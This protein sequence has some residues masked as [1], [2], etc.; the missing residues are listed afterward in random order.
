[1]SSGYKEELGMFGCGLKLSKVSSAAALA[2][3]LFISAFFLQDQIVA[4]LPAIKDLIQKEPAVCIATLAVVINIWTNIKTLKKSEQNTRYAV[5]AAYAQMFKQKIESCT[6]DFLTTLGTMVRKKL[7]NKEVAKETEAEAVEYAYHKLMEAQVALD[8]TN[9]LHS[10]LKDWMDKLFVTSLEKQPDN[11]KC[12]GEI[13]KINEKL[14]F[15]VCE[16]KTNAINS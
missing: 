6:A 5:R 2:V 13:A 16:S 9:P 7:Q 15:V 4:Y 12:L 11:S 3:L 14:R 10:D 1:M 8:M